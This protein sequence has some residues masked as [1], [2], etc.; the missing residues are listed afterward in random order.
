MVGLE[1]DGTVSRCYAQCLNAKNAHCLNA[2]NAHFLNANN[3]G[4][5]HSLLGI[6]LQRH[7]GVK[8]HGALTVVCNAEKISNPLQC[9]KHSTDHPL[10]TGV[11]FHAG[12]S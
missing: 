4:L 11:Q 1:L 2:K 12:V 8:A 7:G 6:R 5:S 10:A 3:T 9:G